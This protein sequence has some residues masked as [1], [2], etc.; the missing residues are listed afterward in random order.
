ML[1]DTLLYHLDMSHTYRT[2]DSDLY[3]LNQLRGPQKG[4][5]CIPV[6]EIASE[7]I[8]NCELLRLCQL[9][10]FSFTLKALKQ[11]EQQLLQN[12]RKTV[13]SRSSSD[14]ARSRVSARGDGRGGPGHCQ[15][16]FDS[17]WSARAYRWIKQDHTCRTSS[18]SPPR[19]DRV[20]LTLQHSSRLIAVRTFT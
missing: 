8:R 10:L 4:D 11:N 17:D 5:R 20:G 18:G 13:H 15:V 6:P 12:V 19:F 1:C 3:A 9:L 16:S 2:T 7:S 14:T